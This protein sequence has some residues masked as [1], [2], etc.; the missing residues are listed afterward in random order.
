MSCEL[1]VVSCELSIVLLSYCPVVL[2]SCSLLYCCPFVL[3]SICQLF[4]V[5]VYLVPGKTEDNTGPLAGP[6]DHQVQVAVLD[7]HL[8]SQGGGEGGEGRKG[9]LERGSKGGR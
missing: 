9:E 5:P 2:L 4:V 6:V 8:H 7:T 1:S 3:L